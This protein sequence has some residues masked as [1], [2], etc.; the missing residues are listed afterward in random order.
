MAKLKK[1]MLDIG[2]GRKQVG[3]NVTKDTETRQLISNSQLQQI[4]G[5]KTFNVPPR[6]NAS[7]IITIDA[8]PKRALLEN[9]LC[10]AY[11]VTD[12]FEITPTDLQNGYVKLSKPIAPG[13][14]ASLEIVDFEGA[15]G[16]ALN[17]DFG[18]VTNQDGSVD[19]LQWK[20]WPLGQ[21][22]KMIAGQRMVVKYSACR[23]SLNK[24]VNLDTLFVPRIEGLTDPTNFV[25]AKVNRNNV[26][27]AE[28][29]EKFL[30]LMRLSNGEIVKIKL[31]ALS[32]SSGL[33]L[34]CA[35]G[36]LLLYA[37]PTPNLEYAGLATGR[38]NL[39]SDYPFT[40]GAFRVYEYEGNGWELKLTD[41]MRAE[42]EA[43]SDQT[44]IS[45]ERYA[46]L[47]M[48][49]MPVGKDKLGLYRAWRTAKVSPGDPGTGNTIYTEDVELFASL[50]IFNMNYEHV[51]TKDVHCD[52]TLLSV[53]EISF[54]FHDYCA[55]TDSIFVPTSNGVR[56]SGSTCWPVY[57]SMGDPGNMWLIPLTDDLCIGVGSMGDAIGICS[58]VYSYN[59]PYDDGLIK[60]FE[61][62]GFDTGFW[63]RGD[64]MLIENTQ[65]LGLFNMS[66]HTLDDLTGNE[67]ETNYRNAVS[68]GYR[69]FLILDM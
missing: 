42:F 36:K 49:V 29:S 50:K 65:K 19:K 40:T 68:Q 31:P 15:P 6:S 33:G 61:G 63:V 64:K 22:G 16:L 52:E 59:L 20:D 32:G 30:E 13:K 45:W 18:V 1:N 66:E 57:G 60:R 17:Q 54:A 8:V 67:V 69:G 46:A 58:S 39:R 9:T 21:A 26:V 12:I 34:T 14:T 38:Q 28:H 47:V 37:T 56:A 4:N 55:A 51:D 7:P 11:T 35:G 10:A 43:I 27:M 44:M 3:L 25:S 62:Y 48:D 5:T 2:V 41:D 23:N 53:P 24:G